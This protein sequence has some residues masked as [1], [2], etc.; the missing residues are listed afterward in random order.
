MKPNSPTVP[1]KEKGQILVILALV[2]IG[3]VAI[4]GLAIDLGYYYVSY[5]RL[6]RA[7]DASALGAT[8]QFK[9]NVQPAD[10]QNAA[11]EFLVLNGV[12]NDKSLSAQVDTCT[13]K[14]LDP[15]LCYDPPR[16]IVR[17]TASADVPMFFLSIMGITSVPITVTSLSEAAAVDLVLVIDR[18]ES[19]GWY[20]ENLALWPNDSI[21]RDPRVCNDDLPPTASTPD[22]TPNLWTG[23]CHPFHE[24]KAAAYTFIDTFMDPKYDRIAIVVYDQIGRPVNFAATG[25]PDLFLYGISAS[26]SNP[27]LKLLDAVRKLWLYDGIPNSGVDNRSPINYTVKGIECTHNSSVVPTGAFGYP[28]RLKDASGGKFYGLDCPGWYVSPINLSTCGTTNMGS[29]LNWAS[30]ILQHYGRQES[31]WVTIL[32]TDGYPNIGFDKDEKAICPEGTRDRAPVCSDKDP[33][34]RHTS[35][36]LSPSYDVSDYVKDQA[37]TLSDGVHSVIFTIGLG[38]EVTSLS[39]SDQTTIPAK[40]A[41]GATLLDYIANKGL[42]GSYYQGNATQ[43]QQI[44]LKIA[45]KIGTRLTK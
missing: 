12:P 25:D 6:R 1:K 8:T 28:C 20:D 42:T 26:D 22:N 45:N 41:M 15:A 38:P 24:V 21:Y 43:L 2:F 7:V 36:P 4:I 10:L 9:K 23:N 35:V 34:N 39:Y 13:T 18:S 33:E 5:A 11:R 40:P 19:M 44:F 30:Y 31:L 27:K 3:L 17:V 14:P 37:D 32:L 29:G 16:K